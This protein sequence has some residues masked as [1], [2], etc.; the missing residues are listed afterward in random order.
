MPRQTQLE[1]AGGHVLHRPGAGVL[2]E[3]RR[4]TLRHVK[5]SEISYPLDRNIL[6]LSG[7]RVIWTLTGQSRL[8]LL[9]ND[10]LQ[11]RRGLL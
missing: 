7:F 10:S 4:V 2:I 5:D 6:H 1:V 3:D 8:I 9:F 11:P